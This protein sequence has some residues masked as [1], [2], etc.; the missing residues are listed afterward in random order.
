[1]PDIPTP[2]TTSLLVGVVLTLQG[3]LVRD[4][5]FLRRRVHDLQEAVDALKK[6]SGSRRRRHPRKVPSGPP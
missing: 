6:R 2:D 4:L 1:M 3:W 5:R